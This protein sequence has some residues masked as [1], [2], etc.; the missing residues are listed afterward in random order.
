MYRFWF[1]RDANAVCRWKMRMN[2]CERIEEGT[3]QQDEQYVLPSTSI[4]MY[5]TTKTSLSITTKQLQSFLQKNNCC[6]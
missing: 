6:T 4:D 2:I 3:Q 5:S 1:V